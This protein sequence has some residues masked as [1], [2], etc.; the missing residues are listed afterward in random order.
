M[1]AAV[2][3]RS[4]GMRHERRHRR[5]HPVAAGS[6]GFTVYVTH[7]NS[8]NKIYAPSARDCRKFWG[9]SGNAIEICQITLVSG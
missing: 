9:A 7:F 8:Y 1:R 4:R 2:G 6:I 5:D 3:S